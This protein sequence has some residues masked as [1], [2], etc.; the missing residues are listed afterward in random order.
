[1]ES[2]P[3]SP[4]S[5]GVIFACRAGARKPGIS[6]LDNSDQRA[7]GFIPVVS[8]QTF[9]L[10]VKKRIDFRPMQRARHVDFARE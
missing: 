6:P 2:P 7:A 9:I 8:E 4:I 10:H 5:L 3:R 1:M